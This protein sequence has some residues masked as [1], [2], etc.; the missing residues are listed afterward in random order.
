MEQFEGYDHN[1]NNERKCIIYDYDIF[2]Y[3]ASF[4]IMTNWNSGMY[5][6]EELQTLPHSQLFKLSVI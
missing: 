2:I 1:I 5:F 6:E 4:I 3:F